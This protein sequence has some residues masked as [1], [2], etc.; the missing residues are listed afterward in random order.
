MTDLFPGLKRAMGPAT[1]EGFYHDFDYVKKVTEAD[2]PR[3]E[4]RMQEIIDANLPIIRQEI[5]L[6]AA[7]KLFKNNPYKLD[8]ISQIE[9]KGE[10]VTVYWTGKPGEPKSD[11]D[12]CR[13]PHVKSTGEIKAFKLLSVAGAYWHGDEKNK[14]LTRIYGTAFF[15]K[16]DLDGYLLKLEEAK[17]RDHRQLGKDLDLFVFADLVGKGLPLL[18]PKGSVIRREL[19]RFIVDE[20]LKRGYQHVYTP[21]LAKTDLYKTSG[22]YPYYKDSMYPPMKIDEEELILRP[23]TCP[24]HFMLYKS[25]PRSYKDLPVRLAELSPQ[26]RY[27]KSGEL[28]GLMRVRTFCLADAHIMVSKNQAKDELKAVLD[29]IDFV[30]HTLGME[31]GID[32]RYRLSLGDRKET[33]KYFQDDKAWEQAEQ[34]L[35]QVLIAAKAPYFEA[36]N[37]AA[38]YGPKIDIQIKNVLGKEE[39]AFT[40]QYDF[41]MPKRFKMVFTNQVGQEEEPIV[42]H[43]SSLGALE[44][45]IAF[46]IEH[47][48]GNFPTWLTPIQVRVLPIGKKHLKY[49][50]KIIE[51]LK[52]A[53]IRAELDDKNDTIQDKIRKGHEDK[54]SYMLIIGDKEVKTKTVTQR[55][56]SGQPGGPFPI[57]TFIGYLREEIDKK[58]I[59]WYNSDYL[60]Q[61]FYKL[62]QYITAS[63]LRIIGPDEK[64][65]GVMTR[66]EAIF[67]A[68]QMGM[69]LILVAD[70]AKPPVAKITDFNKFKYQQVQKEKEGK[71]KTLKT[72]Q[73][74]IRFTPFIAQNDF[75][76]RIE[77]IKS[78][79]KDGHRVKLTV[80]FTG[81]QITRKDFGQEI[82]KKAANQL[83]EFGT[84]ACEPK[85][86][87]KLLW[88]II[89]PIR[90]KSNEKKV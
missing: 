89:A 90:K 38:F 55:A 1:N 53:D 6:S 71:K 69:D 46:L 68:R 45:T 63:Q 51:Q 10:K 59:N 8:W 77:K 49:S 78:F 14:M 61:K 20:E 39:T 35:R 19:E 74:E 67:K 31:K 43:R 41:V 44:R 80:K 23:M 28:S 16:K 76:T 4:T 7:K 62:N 64:Q 66:D 84:Q 88:T 82:L 83:T 48:A 60:M 21:V 79:L 24:H 73:K 50:Q 11:V 81:R 30:N 25:K 85:L 3:I 75:L 87:G 54:V 9:S 17:K 27:E 22:H 29:L 34:I 12:L 72:D 2:F 18:T 47:F 52:A 37:E 33:K 86:Q 13:G 42:I 5:S 15:N 56:R 57:E 40:V 58:T 32:Y 26:F 36:A 65:I 70:Q